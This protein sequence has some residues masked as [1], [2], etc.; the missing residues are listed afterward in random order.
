MKK[1]IKVVT[2]MRL[3]FICFLLIPTFSM[4]V[5]YLIRSDTAADNNKY[6]LTK[7]YLLN[8]VH[9]DIVVD[10]QS[11]EYNPADNDGTSVKECINK[12][13]LLEV[14]LIFCFCDAAILNFAEKDIE[15]NEMMIWCTNTFTIGKCTKNLIMGNT[16]INNIETCM[17]YKILLYYK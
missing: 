7:N 14:K 6:S 16:V 11:C 12:L 4:N 17:N 8:E 10:V 1:T 9:T 15:K 3:I 2:Q 13:K 5:G